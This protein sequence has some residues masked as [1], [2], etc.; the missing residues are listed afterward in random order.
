MEKA[1]P[2]A[3]GGA[4]GTTAR[5]EA[6]GALIFT[7]GD[8]YDVGEDAENGWWAMRLDGIGGRITAAGPG[9]LHTLVCGDYNFN[10]VRRAVAPRER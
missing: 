4:L 10:P 7:W 2:Q 1:A 8:A 6:I 5:D 9:E 3:A